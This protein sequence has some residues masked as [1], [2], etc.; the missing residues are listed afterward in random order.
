MSVFWGSSSEQGAETPHLEK[1]GDSRTGE[2]NSSPQSAK[3]KSKLVPC[4]EGSKNLHWLKEANDTPG[5]PGLVKKASSF[6][7]P[8]TERPAPSFCEPSSG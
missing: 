1:L 2:S 4:E 7:R 3:V 6:R 5:S 8:E